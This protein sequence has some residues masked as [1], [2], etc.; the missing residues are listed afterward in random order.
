[1]NFCY[2][3]SKLCTNESFAKYLFMGDKWRLVQDKANEKA[4]RLHQENPDGAPYPTKSIP[5]TESNWDANEN[6]LSLL[7]LYKRCILDKWKKGDPK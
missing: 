1:M 2:P 7:K 3:P 5:S 6:K 4:W